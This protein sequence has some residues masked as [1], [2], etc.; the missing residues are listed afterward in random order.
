MSVFPTVSLPGPTI[1]STA[2]KPFDPATWPKIT[3]FAL[4]VAPSR[5]S[6]SNCWNDVVAAPKISEPPAAS[7]ESAFSTVTSQTELS[8]ALPKIAFVP[9]ETRPPLRI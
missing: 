5:M 2:E 9:A 4:T 6:R 7:R 8:F 1:P 3:S